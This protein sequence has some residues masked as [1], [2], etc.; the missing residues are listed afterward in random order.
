MIW[1]QT[2]AEGFFAREAKSGALVIS[3]NTA[4]CQHLGSHRR[5]EELNRLAVV[6]AGRDRD[7][8]LPS[9]LAAAERRGLGEDRSDTTSAGNRPAEE[10]EADDRSDDGL[11]HE[12][13]AKLVDGDPDGGEGKQPVD[14]E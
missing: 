1:G 13:P 7:D 6:E 4:G 10:G 12:Q 3:V 9:E 14:D 11:G 8:H 2:A 5:S